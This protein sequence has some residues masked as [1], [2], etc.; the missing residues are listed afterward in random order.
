MFKA[1]LDS[2]TSTLSGTWA[3]HTK[4][5]AVTKRSYH[6]VKTSYQYD[7]Q[8]EL[9]ETWATVYSDVHA[10]SEF[11]E[12]EAITDAAGKLNASAVLL[13]SKDVENMYQRDLEVVRNA[14]YARH[15]YSFKNRQMR[16]FFD[17]FID[18]YVPVSTDVK[19]QL[20]TSSKRT[21]RCSS[22]TRSRGEDYDSFGR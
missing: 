20:T 13:K 5:A 4:G 22:A 14:I 16:Y 8:R 2:N 18:W 15:G 12:Q 10:E 7:P 1:T 19:K 21:L 9:G 3:T 17:N 11:G 6:L